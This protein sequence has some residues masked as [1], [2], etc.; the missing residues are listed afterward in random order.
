MFESVPQAP[1][2][3]ILGLVEAFGLDTNPNKV[4]LT[5]GVYQDAQGVTPI[6]ASVKEAE[7]R[8]LALETQKTY[9]PINGDPRFIA[10]VLDLVFGED[11]PVRAEG[12]AVCAHT[13]G[14]TGALRVAADLLRRVRPETRVWVSDPTWPNH[15]Q[16][17]QAAGLAVQVYRYFDSEKNDLDL[18]G[19]LES[20]RGA[21][22]GDVVVLHACCHNPT[23]VDP[24]PVEWK[25]IAERLSDQGVVPLVDFAYQGFASSLE[26][27][28][29]AV[30]ALVEAGLEVLVCTSFSK[31]FGLYNERVG[32]LTV[33]AGN[34]AIAGRVLSQMKG[35][36]RANYSNPPAHGGAIVATI[37]SDPALR[38]MW[39][40]EL[41]GMR[42]RIHKV[43][44]LFVETM[45]RRGHDFS[46]VGR[47]KGMFSFS[48]LNRSQVERLRAEH[49]VYIVGNGRVNVAGMTEGKM[50][51]LSEAFAR[52]L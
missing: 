35:V 3:P 52:V 11:H 42:S 17:F 41:E 50:E 30:L 27:D 26:D 39:V 43:R 51:A 18:E 22:P 1:P 45:A 32:A 47:Q 49:A 21:A 5:A 9:K 12:R 13:P 15:P 6:L 46:F 25:R 38:A 48:G 24:S 34:A 37:L 16:I 31:I 40:K 8:L 23:G 33:V 4:N 20:L 7:A 10:E 2:D 44:Q 36:I 19:M 14:G 28:R 29:A